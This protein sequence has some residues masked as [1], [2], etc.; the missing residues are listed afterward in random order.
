MQFWNLCNFTNIFK[1]KSNI[2]VQLCS[3]FIYKFFRSFLNTHHKTYLM[4]FIK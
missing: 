4:Y 1:F 3:K 2:L